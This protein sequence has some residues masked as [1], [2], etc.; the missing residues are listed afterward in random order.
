MLA[1]KSA[2][3]TLERVHRP[4]ET[5]IAAHDDKALH[6]E[7]QTSRV[8]MLMLKGVV[9]PDIIGVML[10]L[11]TRQVQKLQDRVHARWEITGGGR[12]IARFRGEALARLDLLEQE[13]WSRYAALS[14]RLDPSPK[15]EAKFLKLL[16]NIQDQRNVLSGLSHKVI[17]RI[18]ALPDQSA[19]V[20]SR[21]AAQHGLATMAARL[22]QLLAKRRDAGARDDRP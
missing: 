7:Q 8:E 1:G 13:G 14:N 10:D 5:T 21:M 6:D 9:R 11:G 2:S 22:T 16:L 19:E 20:V 18:G 3:A 15:D 12:T 17:E 4:P